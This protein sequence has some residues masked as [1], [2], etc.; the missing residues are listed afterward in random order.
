VRKA[1]SFLL[2]VAG[3]TDR[4]KSSDWW[5]YFGSFGDDIFDDEDSQDVP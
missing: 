4:I 1:I 2:G 3:P 5:A